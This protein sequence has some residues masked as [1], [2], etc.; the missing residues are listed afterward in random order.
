MERRS[1]A[2]RAQHEAVLRNIEL[3][4]RLGAS[5]CQDIDIATFYIRTAWFPEVTSHG[6]PGR[7]AKKLR[8]ALAKLLNYCYAH[9][10]SIVVFENLLM[11]KKKRFTKSKTANR[12]ITR[13]AKRQLIQYGV[14][15]ALKY[16]FKA[17]LINTKGTTK[18]KEHD[19]IMQRCGLDRHTASAYL[20]ALKRLRQP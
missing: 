19:K 4:E 10:I 8:R 7:N 18:S 15:M 6:F 14:I 16:G 9:N 3:T 1:Q 20:I 13:F 17:I 11:V 2:A 12:K 5:I